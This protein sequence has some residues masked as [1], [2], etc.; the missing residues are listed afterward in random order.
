MLR[1]NLQAGGTYFALVFGAGFA[2]APLRELW[3]IPRFGERLGE[4]LEMPV[5]LTIILFAAL[6]T[7][8]R[9][10]IPNTPAS[11][12]AVGCVAFALLLVAEIGVVLWVRGLTLA[13]Y[14][15]NRDVVTGTLYL[16]SLLLFALMPF[17]IGRW[18]RTD[19]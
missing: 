19:R 9:F 7:V 12:L 6:W 18:R 5:M 16:F 10:V 1:R 3:A 13:D 17:L 15:A 4:F 11:R 2:L 8:R 14:I